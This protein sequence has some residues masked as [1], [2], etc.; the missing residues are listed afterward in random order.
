MRYSSNDRSRVVS[1]YLSEIREFPILSEEKER[2]LSASL[3]GR[4]KARAV[5]GLVESNLAFVVKI[6]SEYP[7][8]ALPF[9][10]LLN[11]GNIG[12]IEAA[13]RFDHTRGNR[14]LSYAVWWVRKSILRA[15]SEQRSLVRIPL[16]HRKN[17]RKVRA[18]E[19]TLAR[20]LGRMPDREEI[21]RELQT[22]LAKID[23]ILQ[24]KRE[25]LSLDDPIGWESEKSVGECLVDQGSVNPEEEMLREERQEVISLALKVL[26]DQERTVVIQRFGLEGENAAT[27]REIGKRLGITAER[28]RQIEL[29]AMQRLRKV[30]SRNTRHLGTSA[31][32]PS[33]AV[34]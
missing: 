25:N 23:R 12:L 7:N 17:I 14:F 24:T 15:L 1:R 16:S 29:Q 2:E 22:T 26:S 32:A 3:G 31:P 11:E 9:E 13:H 33:A 21:S 4:N 6:V 20:K 18:T 27:L 10:D 19:R 34:P 8:P 5:K 30:M 28:V